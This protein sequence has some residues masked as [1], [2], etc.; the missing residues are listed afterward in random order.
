MNDSQN[1]EIHQLLFGYD[2]GHR[3]LSGSTSLDKSAASTSLVLSD[4][5][6]QGSAP[7]ISGYLT[8]YPLPSI[9]MYAL[10]RTWL[11]TE[12][13]RPGC[14][15]THTL[16]I[17]FSDLVAFDDLQL[18]SLFRRPQNPTDFSNYTVPIQL[19]LTDQRFSAIPFLSSLTAI[20][21]QK[22]FVDPITLLMKALYEHPDDEIFAYAG[23]KHIEE[24]TVL[25]WLQQ[26]PRLRRSFRF[27]TWSISDRSKHSDRFD[28]QF[29]PHLTN[30]L[31]KNK[32]P[33]VMW[34]DLTQPSVPDPDWN[35]A[36]WDVINVNRSSDLRTFLYR[37]GAETEGGRSSYWSLICLYHV[38]QENSPFDP[39][40]IIDAIKDVTPPIDSLIGIVMSGVCLKL[41]RG[42]TVSRKVIEFILNNLGLLK[43]MSETI[44]SEIAK[45][46]WETAPDKLWPLF[47]S[48]IPTE[49]TVASAAAHILSPADLLA[50][51]N[52]DGDVLATVLN[53]NP[54]LAASPEIWSA[55]YPIPQLTS[56]ILSNSLD[57]T[58]LNV[59]TA[60]LQAE[61][62]DI[63]LIGISMFGQT[64]IDVVVQQ[65][66][67]G[68]IDLIRAKRWLSAALQKEDYLSN[69]MSNINI[70]E[71][72]TLELISTFLRYNHRSSSSSSDEWARVLSLINPD[73]YAL[74][75]HLC[76]FLLARAFSGVSPEPLVLVRFALER[77]HNDLMDNK[78]LDEN[79]WNLLSNELPEVSFWDRWDLALRVR[80]AVIKLFVDRNLS[81]SELFRIVSLC[82]ISTD[83]FINAARSS[84]SSAVR[85]YFR[86]EKTF[87]SKAK[88]FKK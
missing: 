56:W 77:V 88:S 18:L 57:P 25:L 63:P 75:F 61:N 13:Q 22:E 44:A 87:F 72:T 27:C 84:S 2:S 32:N 67:N 3:L 81:S 1:I 15:W 82:G 6:G 48:Q 38:L 28:L 73:G 70:H 83:L 8:G 36:V 40:K 5:S 4:L 29:V 59:L 71:A 21:L 64:S 55:P 66:D 80:L 17:D 51:I 30:Q 46:T 23:N 7:A 39:E 49:R 62:P 53:I 65:Y 60:M 31:S 74:S 9:G 14:V 33:S 50:G 34:V 11:A 45:L 42:H 37:Y 19:N 58:P 52:G 24:L 76:A 20:E 35:D 69:A 54:Q 41:D 68:E 10:A 78:N 85:K 26:W 47:K 43:G 79:S 86:E 12:M 16:L